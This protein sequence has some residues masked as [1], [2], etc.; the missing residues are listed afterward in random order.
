VNVRQVDESHGE[1]T[2]VG[3]LLRA[4]MAAVRDEPTAAW[5]IGVGAL[6]F[7]KRGWW[8]QAP[9]LPVPDERYW[10]F[11][12]ETAYGDEGAHVSPHDVAEAARWARRA[13]TARR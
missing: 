2:W 10:R 3:Q 5:A 9:F 6:R 11:R 4:S 13:R 1:S 12:M 8:R 7:A